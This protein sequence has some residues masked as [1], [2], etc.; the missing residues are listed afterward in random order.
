LK[1]KNRKALVFYHS[2]KS[3]TRTRAKSLGQYILKYDPVAGVII[4]A[5]NINT[6]GNRLIYIPLYL[7]SCIRPILKIKYDEK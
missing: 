2:G 7:T 4:S 5:N 1:W 3:G 6:K